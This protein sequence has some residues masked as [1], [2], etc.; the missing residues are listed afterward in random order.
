LTLLTALTCLAACET[1]RKG[2]NGSGD[3]LPQN[4]K[5]NTT[6]PS[7]EN[8]PPTPAKPS[9]SNNKRIPAVIP[10]ISPG[11]P[12]SLDSC[13]AEK[14]LVSLD[15]KTCVAD[16]DLFKSPATLKEWCVA[17]NAQ[18]SVLEKSPGSINS[19]VTLIQQAQLRDAKNC[20]EIEAVLQKM[21]S[22]EVFAST[23]GGADQDSVFEFDLRPFLLMGNLRSILFDRVV[24]SNPWRLSELKKVE[25]FWLTASSGW[26]GNWTLKQAT[27]NKQFKKVAVIDAHLNT[28]VLL[29]GAAHL[30]TLDLSSNQLK[31]LEGFSKLTAL[32]SI[33]LS[34]NELTNASL[35][36]LKNLTSLETLILKNNPQITDLSEL[37][38][39]KNSLKSIVIDDRKDP[40]NCPSEL[41]AICKY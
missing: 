12:V 27:E 34:S 19:I 30:E 33:S 8:Q 16:E 39:L 25:N 41:K 23:F 18:K 3:N 32:K 35:G 40:I 20:T 11:Q 5:E 28:T 2:N 10:V 6:P 21:E 9:N 38:P 29:E 7:L 31:S 13:A 14:K 36:G 1:K 22:V 26:S 17:F 37:L 15:G 4:G 24:L